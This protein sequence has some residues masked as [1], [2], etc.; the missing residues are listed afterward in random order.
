MATILEHGRVQAE[1]KPEIEVTTN[2]SLDSDDG[3]NSRV[4]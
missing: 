1:E 2:Y 3:Y 4:L